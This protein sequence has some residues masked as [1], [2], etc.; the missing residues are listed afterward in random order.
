MGFYGILWDLMG[1]YG[2]L[3]DLMGFNG[4]LWDLMGFNG[5]LWDFM[6]FYGILW[7]LMVVYWD[8]MGFTR[9]GERTNILPW[10]DPPFF[11]WENP[12]FRLG[13]FQ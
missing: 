1:F 12:L 3:W 11:W 4:I 7:D 2:I 9:P 13:H 8:Q 10:K 5:I 6:G